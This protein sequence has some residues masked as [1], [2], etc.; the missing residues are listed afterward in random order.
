MV[1]PIVT[2]LG[3]GFLIYK[4]FNFGKKRGKKN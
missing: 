4:V 1:L 3:L 2:L